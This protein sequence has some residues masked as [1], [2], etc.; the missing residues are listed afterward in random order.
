MP[1]KSSRR[2]RPA[3]TRRFHKPKWRRSSNPVVRRAVAK[4]NKKVAKARKNT[5]NF[6]KPSFVPA[7]CII[8]NN[9]LTGWQNQSVFGTND[10]GQSDP[11]TWQM[12]RPLNLNRVATDYDGKNRTVNAIWARNTRYDIEIMPAKKCLGGFQ[13]RVVHGYFKGDSNVATQGLT[14]SGMNVIYPNINSRLSDREHAG[15]S[16]FY[17]KHKET[18][19]F[20]PSQIYDENGS[21]DSIAAEQMVA[22]YRPKTI[23]GNFNYNRKITYENSD[24]DSQNGWLPFIGFQCK[25]LPGQNMLTRPNLPSEA[26][27]G[28]NPGPRI[29]LRC[30]TYFSDIH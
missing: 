27:H 18:H 8:K 17:F 2:T 13:L 28:T 26:D 30:S 5:R 9:H 6:Q 12:I 14:G 20:T 10:G 21:D 11:T 3:G 29:N 7:T 24:G 1:T 4:A 19:T 23:Y 16:D 15:K 22:L 25:P